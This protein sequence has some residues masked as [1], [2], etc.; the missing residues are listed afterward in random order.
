MDNWGRGHDALA[1]VGRTDDCG[2]ALTHLHKGQAK[3]AEGNTADD[4][5]EAIPSLI[6]CC[7]V[8]A[9]VIRCPAFSSR[10][11]WPD[12]CSSQHQDLPITFRRTASLLHLFISGHFCGQWQNALSSD[13]ADRACCHRLRRSTHA[14]TRPRHPTMPLQMPS[15]RT[16]CARPSARLT[17]LTG[18]WSRHD[19]LYYLSFSTP[20]ANHY[21]YFL[22]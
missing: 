5:R 2:P 13:F 16:A 9:D 18:V 21:M 17:F 12:P 8:T 4:P 11:R 3:I 10:H 15:H 14:H 6:G 7:T 19:D 22:I 1:R 20:D